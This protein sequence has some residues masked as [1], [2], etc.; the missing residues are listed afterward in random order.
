MYEII[1]R[2]SSEQN[3][4]TI[5]RSESNISADDILHRPNDQVKNKK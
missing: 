2:S 1:R 3:V 5:Y 4:N